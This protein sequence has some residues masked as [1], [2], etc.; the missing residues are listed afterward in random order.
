MKFC[1]ACGAPVS[2]RIPPGDNR[3]RHVCDACTTVHYQNPTVVA[4]CI[5][6]W[7]DKVLLCRRAIEPRYGLWTLPGGFMEK[8]ETT[9][10][11][12]AREMWEEARAEVDNL[13]LYGVYNLKHISQV[14]VMFRGDLRAGQASAGAESLE[15]GLYERAAVPWRKLAFPIVNEAL[16]RY[17][18][19]REKGVHSVHSSDITRTAAGDYVVH[20]HP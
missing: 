14:Y 10:E 1:S 5:A 4:G 9:L 8:G 18:E 16:E 19:E 11:A 13:T 12:A 3:A 20:R 2:L 6:V 7:E 15:V 17:F